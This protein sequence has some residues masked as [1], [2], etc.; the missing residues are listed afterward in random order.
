MPLGPP[1]ILFEG[2]LRS[3]DE[4]GALVASRCAELAPELEHGP[5]L[6][7]L[8]MAN[9]PEAVALLLA[10]SCF[11]SPVVLLPADLRGWRS[12]PPIPPGT[13]LFLPRALAHLGERAE[14]LGLRPRLLAEPAAPG[15]ARHAPLMS[16]PGFVFFTSG[17]TGSPRP[18]FRTSAQLIDAGLAPVRAVGFPAEGGFIAS[19]PLDR[20]FG[21][22]H[23]L[24]AAMA[25][26]RPVALLA[27]FGHHAVLDLFV[28]GDYPYWA[29][30]PMM[31][32][33]LGRCRLGDA[34]PSPHPAPAF[35]VIS[36]RLSA[37]VCEA[38]RARFGVSLRQLYGTTETGAVTMD[39]AA[40][41]LVRSL[42]AG[43]PLPGVA[44]R[45]GDDPRHSLPPGTVGRV[46]ISSPGCSPGYGFPP[47][48]EPL[49]GSD[50]WWA[51][52]DVGEVDDDGRLVITGRLDDCVRTVT[53]HLVNTSMVAAVL[54]DF[55]GL[56]EAVVVPVGRVGEPTLGALVEA[57]TP[58]DM[59][60]VRQHLAARL[61]AASMPRLIERVRALPRLSS[62]KPDRRACI[63]WLERPA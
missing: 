13:A 48:L 50:G 1:A 18:V 16:C 47:D 33:A 10:L 2:R 58:L 41:P 52:P 49:A 9:H 53:G 25:L 35:C 54:E 46:W 44:V 5:P 15:R 43:R 30:T 11:P 6:V 19:L 61:P 59:D 42:S 55:P 8:P 45:I 32:D 62:G 40:A 20:T 23:G 31:A 56:A 3:A 4:M 12:T 7:A 34:A 21:M 36:G 24:M 63:A 60:G 57:E 37:P 22:H 26:R 28:T 38:F 17:S 39:A 14:Q 51:T 27:H 29:G